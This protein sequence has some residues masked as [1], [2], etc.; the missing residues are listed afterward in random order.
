MERQTVAL[1]IRGKTKKDYKTKRETNALD[2]CWQQNLTF[3]GC[4]N[5]FKSSENIKLYRS[6]IYDIWYFGFD[7][8]SYQLSID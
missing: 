4:W 3:I 2:M 6:S 8:N 1:W 7:K 5:V